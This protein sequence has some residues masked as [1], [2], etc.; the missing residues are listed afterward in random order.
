MKADFTLSDKADGG[1]GCSGVRLLRHKSIEATWNL[2][3][4][5][6]Q[7]KADGSLVSSYVWTSGIDA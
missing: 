7:F 1:R 4:L 2:I 6:N 3:R 5:L